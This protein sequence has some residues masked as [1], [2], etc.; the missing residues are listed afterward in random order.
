MTNSTTADDCIDFDHTDD[1]RR[2]PPLD[3]L[4]TLAHLDDVE[5]TYR[6]QD[7]S[8]V[9]VRFITDDGDVTNGDRV[10]A[11]HYDPAGSRVGFHAFRVNSTDD[12]LLHHRSSNVDTV[13]VA[14]QYALAS[15][16]W[17]VSNLP[18]PAQLPAPS[19][20]SRRDDEPMAIQLL[21]VRDVMR[22]TADSVSA[23]ALADVYR[24]LANVAE[25]CALYQLHLD[26]VMEFSVDGDAST[27]DAHT[28][29]LERLRS[30]DGVPDDYGDSDVVKGL[31]KA[32]FAREDYA[33]VEPSSDAG[34][35]DVTDVT[36][37][38][39][40]SVRAA[41]RQGLNY[42]DAIRESFPGRAE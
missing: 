11:H 42:H 22:A 5:W 31:L 2:L 4:F 8:R 24:V 36:I 19:A 40:E 25:E 13:P 30:R 23:G 7:E 41:Y 38:R 14:V 35:E 32:A 27:E 34:D 33:F 1:G 21:D 29:T 39:V 37:A 28:R 6:F 16:G 20:E 10:E 26:V 18:D 15:G 9:R 3:Y 12:Y 17:T